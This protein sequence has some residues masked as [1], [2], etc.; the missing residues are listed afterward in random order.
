MRCGCR[1]QA[2]GSSWCR[3]RW[4]ARGSGIR[5]GLHV[6]I[7]LRDGDRGRAIRDEAARR[8]VALTALSDY[9]LGRTEDSSML[10][11][12]YARSSEAVI[13]AGVRELAA[14]VQAVRDSTAPVG[15][16]FELC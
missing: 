9:Y 1:P 2:R 15:S 11:L 4:T 3:C 13:R 14:A 5:A 6:T 7:Q 12:G 10:L 16:G 8:G